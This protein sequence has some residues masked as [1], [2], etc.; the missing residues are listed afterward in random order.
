MHVG[1]DL[2]EDV[3]GNLSVKYSQEYMTD[4][5]TERAEDIISSHDRSRPLYLQLAHL[6]VHASDSK[7]VM[8]VRDMEE[9]NATLGYIEDFNRR[10]FA[11]TP[12]GAIRLHS[13]CQ[14]CCRNSR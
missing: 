6:A 2:H 4:V 1:Y 8:E 5:I 14:L 9:V 3:A 7:E 11:G 10:K 13:L 12:T